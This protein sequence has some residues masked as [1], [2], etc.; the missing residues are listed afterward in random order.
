MKKFLSKVQWN[1]VGAATLL[2]LAVILLYVMC[3][4]TNQAM[5]SIPIKLAFVGE[6]SYDGENW[7]D[8]DE[9][10]DLSALNGEVILRETVDNM[11]HGSYNAGA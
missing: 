10:T 4:G 11:V 9:R 3:S 2:I 8:I 7:V 5:A 6:Y 1:I